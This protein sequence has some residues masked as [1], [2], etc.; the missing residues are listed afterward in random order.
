MSNKLFTLGPVEMYQVTKRHNIVNFRTDEYG[1]IVKK[2]L[3]S[4]SG[5]LGNSTPNSLIYIACSGTGAMEAVIENC[6]N[7]K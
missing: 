7:K 5:Y 1:N 2:C 4:L 6:T 3:S